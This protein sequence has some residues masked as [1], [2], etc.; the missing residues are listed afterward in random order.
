MIR[1]AASTL[2]VSLG[3]SASMALAEDASEGVYQ[4]PDTVKV[5]GERV[6]TDPMGVPAAATLLE[7]EDWET[8]RLTGVDDALEF[9]PGVVAQTRSGG[10]DVRVTIRGFGARGAGERS[11][12]GTTR[13]VRFALDGFPLTEPDGRTSLDFADIGLMDAARVI[14]SN[15]SGLFGPASGGVVDLYSATKFSAPFGEVSAQFGSFGY[16]RQHGRF[17]MMA[18]STRIGF[19]IATSDFDGWRDHSGG[20]QTTI[21]GSVLAD[22][23]P[24]TNVAVTLAATTNLQRQPG[25]LTQEEFDANPLQADPTYVE[26]NARR[27]NRIG[28]L[29]AKL[30][31]RFRTDDLLHIALFVEPKTIHRSE[32]NRFRDFQRAHTGGTAFYRLPFDIGEMPFR[33]T[34]GVDDAFQDGSVLFYD[35]GPDGTR[36]TELIAN[37]REG[38]NTFGAFT[39]VGVTLAPKWDLMAGGRWDFIH[40]ISEDHMA[41]E[42]DDTRTLDRFTPR[43]A[44]SYRIRPEHSLYA[45]LSSGIEAPAFN[46]IDPPPPYDETTTLNPFL[47]P[48]YSTTYEVGA[49]G[50]FPFG[51]GPSG[52]GYDVALYTLTVN[53]DIIPYNNGAFY[54]TA[55]ESQRSGVELGLNGRMNF[56]LS[57]RLALAATDNKYVD[58]ETGSPND[59]GDIV[60]VRYDDNE[61]AGIPSSVVNASLRYQFREWPY[62]EAVYSHI[63]EYFANDANT[64]VVE[65]YSVVDLTIGGSHLFGSTELGGFVS[66]R[67]LTD[68]EYAA[69]AYVNG[70]NG[71][72]L[73]PGMEANVLVGITIRQVG[74]ERE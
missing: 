46:E 44:L 1:L 54:T 15:T 68:E 53:N 70:V 47:E 26:Q 56:G 41:P 58:Y 11:N 17:G 4:L 24:R 55:G 50:S 5:E 65:A 6:A 43:G 66:G 20:S 37:Q 36:G 2:L 59:S 60:T 30:D 49:K 32:R 51:E 10:Q 7:R 35:L 19:S 67:N 62:I 3:L 42:L 13:G 31:Q 72:Y 27:D 16:A 21:M 18:G 45:A 64:D 40:Y 74:E 25:A 39:E 22:P 14:R 34:T 33:W 61:S 73:E 8:S 71:R 48:A 69:S 23:S 63:G 9:V 29:G 57:G 28:R 38:I 12:A 52:L